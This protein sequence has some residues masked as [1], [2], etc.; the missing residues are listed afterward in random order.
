VRNS[1][2]GRNGA[3]YNVVDGTPRGH[4]ARLAIPPLSFQLSTIGQ[5]ISLLAY[6]CRAY[7]KVG[8]NGAVRLL[9]MSRDRLPGQG[10]RRYIGDAALAMRLSLGMAMTRL[11]PSAT[12]VELS[13]WFV[14]KVPMANGAAVF[15]AEEVEVPRPLG[16]R[17]PNR[18][19]DVA[20]H[21][22]TPL[23]LK[24][25]LVVDHAGSLMPRREHTHSLA[26]VP[27]YYR[28]FDATRVRAI[29]S[30]Y[31]GPE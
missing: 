10:A 2:L 29:S 1:D 4:L 21:C 9:G 7:S 16:F 19:Q 23:A 15:T 3:V 28:R 8:R 18:N 5:L 6:G 31:R 24:I 27:S 11:V 20:A 26:T 30:R 17:D 22:A 25:L 13:R 14:G 12:L